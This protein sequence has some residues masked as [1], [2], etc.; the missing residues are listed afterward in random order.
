MK[1]VTFC[2]TEATIVESQSCS[3]TSAE[4]I[5][6]LWYTKEELK[7]QQRRLRETLQ[8]ASDACND[9]DEDVCLRGLEP[10]HEGFEAYRQRRRNFVQA[11]LDVQSDMKELNMVD[12]KGLQAFASAHSRQDCREARRRG[13]QGAAAVNQPRGGA[14]KSVDSNSRSSILRPS[15]SMRGIQLVK[16][17][18][19]HA[20][21]A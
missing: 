20:L 19:I 13:K 2:P 11:L 3:S 8:R 9:S 12:P 18:S 1:T 21:C 7:D 17:D 5:E 16:Q 14:P 4:A 6:S 10:L 15:S